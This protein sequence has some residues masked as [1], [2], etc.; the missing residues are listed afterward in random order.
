[1]HMYMCVYMFVFEVV[2]VHAGVH[3]CGGQ[4]QTSLRNVAGLL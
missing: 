4:S 3:E 2:C 1:M